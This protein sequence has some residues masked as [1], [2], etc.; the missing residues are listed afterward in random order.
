MALRI[1]TLLEA[2][3]EA[4]ALEAAAKARI[5]ALR[6]VLDEEA[7]RRYAEDGAAPTWKARDAGVVRFDAPGDWTATV[8]DPAAFG[9][10]LAER[11]PEEVLGVIYVTAPDLADATQALEF[12][13]VKPVET[14]TE[15][16]QPFGGKY[17]EGLVVDVEE[18]AHDDG[19]VDRT[20][21]VVDPDTGQLV[22]GVTATRANGAG[23]LV[24]TLDKVRKAR[25]LEAAHADAAHVLAEAT[26]GREVPDDPSL[27]ADHPAHPRANEVEEGRVVSLEEAVA[28]GV[29]RPAST[30]V[31]DDD[32]APLPDRFQT[33]PAA[34]EGHRFPY[35]GEGADGA[36]RSAQIDREEADGYDAGEQRD[37]CL[38]SAERWEAQAAELDAAA[39]EPDEPARIP[40]D[41]R[42]RLVEEPDGVK[43]LEAAAN[44]EELRRLARAK[45]VNPGGTKRDVTERLYAAGVRAEDLRP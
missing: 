22:D 24:V 41:D 30:L 12:I 35:V 18:D 38:A 36:R 32:G 42:D 13:G 7:R 37:A 2:I 28:A 9:S 45:G 1:P 44:R 40:V 33:T 15:V 10:Y 27:P 3:L 39:T 6:K 19:T 29:V 11:H 34:V 43:A 5:S 31:E 17:L 8:A 16:R 25:A 21:T 26:G 14:R 23:R 20:I 4:T